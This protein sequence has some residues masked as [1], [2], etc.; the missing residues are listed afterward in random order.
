MAKA[1]PSRA[2]APFWHAMR[3][4][5]VYVDTNA[6][7]YLLEATPKLGDAVAA[8]LS[9]SEQRELFACAGEAVHAELLVKP[10]RDGDAVAVGV[11]DGLFAQQRMLE[12]LPHD[13]QVFR[14]AASLRALHRLRFIDALHMATALI[15]RCSHFVTNDGDFVQVDGITMVLLSDVL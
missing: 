7:I 1:K 3:G 13:A 9:A 12:V 10:M 11:L 5:R 6:F 8:L 2:S 15:H 14:L 4:G